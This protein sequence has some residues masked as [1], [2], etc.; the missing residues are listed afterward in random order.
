MKPGL[1]RL[2]RLVGVGGGGEAKGFGRLV[3]W[4]W[5]P[6]SAVKGFGRLVDWGSVSEVNGFGMIWTSSSSLEQFSSS[7]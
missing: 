2:E 4:D 3:D 6:V 7:L 5:D 1:P